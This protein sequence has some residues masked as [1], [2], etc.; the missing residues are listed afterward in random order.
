MARWWAGRTRPRAIN[1]GVNG[2]GAG[3]DVVNGLVVVV[4]HESRVVE[5][6]STRGG[7]GMEGANTTA[8]GFRDGRGRWGDR[9][10]NFC[11]A[12]FF[13]FCAAAFVICE[14]Q[15]HVTT[16]KVG[17]GVHESGDGKSQRVNGWG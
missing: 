6:G 15:K 16:K 11:S 7:S 4:M 13:F 14:C 1:E 5:K 2:G 8:G 10:G 9:T 3:L 17:C 12:F